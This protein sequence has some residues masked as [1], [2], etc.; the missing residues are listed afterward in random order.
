MQKVILLTLALAAV[1]QHCV[2]GQQ[3]L[4]YGF[5]G[6]TFGGIAGAFRYGLGAEGRIAPHIPA[7]GEI[8]GISKNGTGVLASGNATFHIPSREIDP[9]LTGGVSIG[10]KGGRTGLWVNLGG[11]LNYW[12]RPRL[13]L[14]AELR[15]YPGGYDL[16]SFAE[17]RL[18]V[19][20][21]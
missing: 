10:H 1:G 20:F 18:G 9:F 17:F 3:S 21:R 6:G 2:F 19:V 5:L 11:G 7:G 16:N 15:G 13:G 14:R 4:G 8:G 12:F